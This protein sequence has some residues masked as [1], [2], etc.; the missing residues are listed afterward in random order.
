VLKDGNLNQREQLPIQ[1]LPPKV[2]IDLDP[3][4]VEEDLTKLPTNLMKSIK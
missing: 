3:I 1:K 2:N 4:E